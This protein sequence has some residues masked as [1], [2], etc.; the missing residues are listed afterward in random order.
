M[1]AAVCLIGF[2]GLTAVVVS[3]RADALDTRL[4]LALAE[5]RRPW[6][7]AGMKIASAAGAGVVGVPFALL[8]MLG[9]WSRG[10]GAGARG[11]AGVVLSGWALY[12]LAKLAVRRARP[13]VVT[14]LMHGAGWY[15]YPSGHSMLAPLL[16]GLGAVMWAAPWSAPRARAGLVCLAALLSAVIGLSRVY[17]GVHYPTDVVGGFLLGTAWSALWLWRWEARRAPT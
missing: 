17:L 12:G 7:T 10:R 11:Y 6:L 14:R 13:H 1:L 5:Y 16:F 3:G 4:M 9:L 15:S 8:F 2:A